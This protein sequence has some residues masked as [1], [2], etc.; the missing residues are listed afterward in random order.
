MPGSVCGATSPSYATR[1]RLL[2]TSAR[3]RCSIRSSCSPCW[4]TRHRSAALRCPCTRRMGTGDT[5]VWWVSWPWGRTGGQRTST[6]PW[7]CTPCVSQSQC[8]IS[9]W[10]KHQ[11]PFLKTVPK[12]IKSVNN[13]AWA[14]R[15]TGTQQVLPRYILKKKRCTLRNVLYQIVWLCGGGRK[16]LRKG[17]CCER[18]EFQRCEAVQL[19]LLLM[20]KGVEVALD[21]TSFAVTFFCLN[22][23]LYST[24]WGAPCA[25]SV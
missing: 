3:W 23:S 6:G 4:S 2:S 25:R 18:T 21:M 1:R 24:H 13:A 9:C 22:A 8:G 14:P 20:L 7:W 17:F 11:R 19:R 16:G 12:T 10:F 15:S 5:S